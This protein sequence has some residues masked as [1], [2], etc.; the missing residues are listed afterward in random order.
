MVVLILLPFKAFQQEVTLEQINDDSY[1]NHYSLNYDGREDIKL[2]R[3]SGNVGLDVTIDSSKSIIYA[4]RFYDS[5]LLSMIVTNMTFDII[6][7]DSIFIYCVTGFVRT[8]YKNG[9]LRSRYTIEK[10]KCNEDTVEYFSRLTG[11]NHLTNIKKNGV[12]VDGFYLEQGDFGNGKDEL[13]LIFVEQEKIEKIYFISPDTTVHKLVR[14]DKRKKVIFNKFW[15]NK[16]KDSFNIFTDEALYNSALNP[17]PNVENIPYF[18][19]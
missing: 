6:P 4:K 3:E 14:G 1:Y 8:Y 9:K 5:G 2:Y 10:E 19:D 11:S 7:K 15:F 12:L 17:F 16:F 18:Q 13:I